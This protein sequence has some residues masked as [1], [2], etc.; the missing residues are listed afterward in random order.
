MIVRQR[1]GETTDA[2][3]L[4][5]Y[6]SKM[7]TIKMLSLSFV[8]FMVGWAPITMVRIIDFFIFPIFQK[9]CNASFTYQLF[10]WLSVSSLCYNPFIYCWFDPKFREVSRT[11]LNCCCFWQRVPN[12]GN[13]IGVT[14][15]VGGH[16]HS[17]QTPSTQLSHKP[18]IRCSSNGAQ[19]II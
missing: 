16:S 13:I 1:I 15:N 11:F 5:F 8:A 18:A 12:N 2:Q 9:A 14:G 7:R 6:K 3:T 17:Q 10:Y 19:I 4:K